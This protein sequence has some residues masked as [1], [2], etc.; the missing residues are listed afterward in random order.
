MGKQGHASLAGLTALG[1]E[2]GVTQHTT[3]IDFLHRSARARA[4]SNRFD[5]SGMLGHRKVVE[6]RKIARAEARGADIF[7]ICST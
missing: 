4:P 2:S 1:I 7:G 5:D 6:L 3:F